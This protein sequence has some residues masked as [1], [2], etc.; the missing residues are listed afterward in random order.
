MEEELLEK[1]E[2][3]IVSV[4]YSIRVLCVIVR[5]AAVRYALQEIWRAQW[6]PA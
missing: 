6:H 3:G 5:K 2:A 1:S 4:W